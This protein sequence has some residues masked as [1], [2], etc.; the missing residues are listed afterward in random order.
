MD[1]I[2]TVD[3][4]IVITDPLYKRQ[5]ETVDKMRT[6][7]M[8]TDSSDPSSTRHVMQSITAMRIY[9]QVTRIVKYLDLMDKLENKLYE[10]IDCA[11]DNASASD[12]ETF[13]ILLDIQTRLQKNMIDS[14]KLLQPYLNMQSYSEV[15]DLASIDTAPDD[16]MQIMSSEKRDKLRANAQSVLEMLD[17]SG[18]DGDE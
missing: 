9:H 14:D 12:P 17:L 10:S 3:T 13:A 4:A 8:A 5:K 6:A 18:G 16:S 1:N 15:V 7:L 11:I 2:E